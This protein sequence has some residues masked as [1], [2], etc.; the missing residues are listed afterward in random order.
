MGQYPISIAVT[1]NKDFNLSVLFFWNLKNPNKVVNA[2][3]LI[4]TT[5]TSYA[6]GEAKLAG[7]ELAGLGQGSFWVL[8]ERILK[9]EVFGRFC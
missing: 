1:E 4:I 7:L 8:L 6:L 5:L 2:L 3:T 9:F